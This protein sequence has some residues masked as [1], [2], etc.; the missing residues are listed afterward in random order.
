MPAGGQ[1]NRQP[2]TAAGR[3]AHEAAAFS[4]SDGRPVPHRGQ[5]RLPVG[6]LPLPPPAQPDATPGLLGTTAGC[7]CCASSASRTPTWRPPQVA[8]ATYGVDWVD[9]DDPSPTFPYTPGRPAPTTNN[10]GASPTSA[11]RA[12]RRAR[13]TSRGSEGAAYDDGVDVLH[14]HPGRRRGRDRRPD[15]SP[16]LRERHGPGLGVRP[17]GTRLTCS[18]TSHPARTCST[19]PTTSPPARAARSS[20]ARTTSTTTT[21]AGSPAGGSAVRHRPQ[22]PAAPADR[23][24]PRFDDEFAGSTFC[25]DGDTLFVNIQASAGSR[26]RSGVRGAA[27]GSDRP[28]PRRPVASAPTVTILRAWGRIRRE[29]TACTG[30][31]ALTCVRADSHPLDVCPDARPHHSALPLAVS[32]GRASASMSARDLVGLAEQVPA[33]GPLRAT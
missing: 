28:L 12:G 14:L 20:S 25:P 5:L 31:T 13:P 4:P 26:S 23:R 9:I 22:P 11:T 18:S 27:S 10:D 8:G 15:R 2:I 17:A 29:Y 19:S 33:P 32:A 1:S 6:L 7:R 3:F 16:R 30:P 21:S 24:R